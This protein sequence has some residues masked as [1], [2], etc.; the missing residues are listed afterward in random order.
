MTTRKVFYFTK[1][2][3]LNANVSSEEEKPPNYLDPESDEEGKIE[4]LKPLRA[5][6]NADKV[7]DARAT[8]INKNPNGHYCDHILQIGFKCCDVQNAVYFLDFTPNEVAKIY[9]RYVNDCQKHKNEFRI[10]TKDELFAIGLITNH[11][12]FDYKLVWAQH[13]KMVT[14]SDGSLYLR[15]DV[16]F[17]NY[18]NYYYSNK[19]LIKTSLCNIKWG[20]KCGM[21]FF[22]LF[23]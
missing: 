21:Y 10:L 16:S 20:S 5:K 1:Q 13:C 6:I 17:E 3:S 4:I 18:I 8:M 19:N 15:F 22:I 14:G 2:E 12:E 23:D 9:N 7:D 11:T